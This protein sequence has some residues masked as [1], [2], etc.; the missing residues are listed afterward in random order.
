MIPCVRVTFDPLRI[1]IYTRTVAPKSK[2]ISVIDSNATAIGLM[3][4]DDPKMKTI[5]KMLEPTTFPSANSLS[6]FR[7]ATSEVTNSGREVPIATI[8]K[9]I[10]V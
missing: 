1:K 3:A 8:V 10:N 7:A 5:L 6:P 9:P 2:M 4:T